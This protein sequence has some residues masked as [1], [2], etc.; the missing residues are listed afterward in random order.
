M[1]LR[2][3]RVESLTQSLEGH[4]IAIDVSVL[5]A[6][7]LD[8]DSPSQRLLSIC[9]RS[10]LVVSNHVEERA[11]RVLRAAA[12]HLIP[13]FSDALLRLAST[14]ALERVVMRASAPVPPWAEATLSDED[15]C[16]LRGAVTGCA[17]WLFTHDRDFFKR[18]IPGMAVYSPATFVWDP[19]DSANVVRGSDAF[20]FVGV[21][22]PQ[23]GTDAVRAT[24]E[25]FFMFEIAHFIRAYYA[26]RD[27]AF[28]VRWHRRAGHRNGLSVPGNVSANGYNFVAVTVEPARVTLFVNGTQRECNVN[29]GTAPVQTTFHPF[30][31]AESQHR[32]FGGCLF[33]LTGTAMPPRAIRR[34]YAAHAIQLTD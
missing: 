10:V 9:G 28:H 8:A 27:G 23:W 34:H 30:M 32:I 15:L 6:G 3:E 2:R 17:K 12:P 18:A 25:V 7:L 24:D 33:R 4:R 31:S 22:Y 13:E 11:L 29:V 1:P 14:T 26:A 20:T 5:L 19:L 16:V 21:F